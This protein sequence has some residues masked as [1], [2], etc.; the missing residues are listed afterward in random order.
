MHPVLIPTQILREFFIFD[1]NREPHS[2]TYPTFWP[3]L[4]A[5]VSQKWEAEAQEETQRMKKGKQ[6][7]FLRPH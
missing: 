1:G 5:M 6:V 7:S 4:V 2:V 3:R